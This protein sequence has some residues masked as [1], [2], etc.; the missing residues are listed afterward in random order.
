MIL[1]EFFRHVWSPPPSENSHKVP[2]LF[3]QRHSRE[4]SMTSSFFR[5]NSFIHSFLLICKLEKTIPSF[6]RETSPDSPEIVTHYNDESSFGSNCSEKLACDKLFEITCINPSVNFFGSNLK[7][8][9]FESKMTQFS[10]KQ[11]W[12]TGL[13]THNNN[14]DLSS[15]THRRIHPQ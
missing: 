13:S 6:L 3:W 11:L 14:S 10:V 8:S 2:L 12:L 4:F 1:W 5:I 15:L 9:F 7:Y